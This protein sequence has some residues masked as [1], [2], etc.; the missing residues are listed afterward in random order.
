MYGSGSL[1]IHWLF[2]L[3]MREHELMNGWDGDG[4]GYGVN[5]LDMMD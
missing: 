4:D 2:F 5:C 1:L 3:R